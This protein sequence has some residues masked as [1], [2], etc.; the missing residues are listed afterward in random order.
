M[1]SL[2]L[3]QSPYNKVRIGKDNDGGYIVCE[4][5]DN[6]DLFIIGFNIIQII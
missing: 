6:Y 4:L 3:Y 2:I 1:E 5:P